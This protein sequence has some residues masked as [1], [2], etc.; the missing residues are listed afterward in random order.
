MK[1][2][3]QSYNQNQPKTKKRVFDE[4]KSTKGWKTEPITDHWIE[5]FAQEM[6]LWAQTNNT[7]LVLDQYFQD[8]GV[9]QETKYRWL[10]KY[11][12]VRKAYDEALLAI[13]IRRESGAIHKKYETNMIA[14]MMW[15]YSKAWKDGAEWR[16][17][18][19]AKIEES[20]NVQSGIKVV[21]VPVFDDRPTPEQVAQR[22]RKS[23]QS[24]KRA[25]AP[26]IEVT[27]EDVAERAHK[28]T[29][30]SKN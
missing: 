17:A 12:L 28:K 3:D 23:M 11:P 15:H 22:S 2:K 1:P 20:K 27:P 7:A 8:K 16:A 14:N 5:N 10:E 26:V 21:E 24:S 4:Y 9:C 25:K 30:H 29:K 13:G 6:L 18:L 19:R